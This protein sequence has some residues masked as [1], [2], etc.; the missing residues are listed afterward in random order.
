MNEMSE[1]L[2][3]PYKIR[4]VDATLDMV[5]M[6]IRTVVARGRAPFQCRSDFEFFAKGIEVMLGQHD[7]FTCYK[8]L[9]MLY[10]IMPQIPCIFW[11]GLNRRRGAHRD[12][13]Q[14]HPGRHQLLQP[15]LPLVASLP[16]PLPANLAVPC[17]LR[18]QT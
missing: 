12:H 17:W 15:V 16:R 2:D 7:L 18:T 9:W 4:T 8:C 5:M 3:S 1:M 6:W 11:C 14:I 10:E 13:H